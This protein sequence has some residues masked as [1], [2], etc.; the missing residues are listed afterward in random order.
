MNY[1]PNLNELQLIRLNFYLMFIKLI[2]LLL[3][4]FFDKSFQELLNPL[5]LLIV[6]LNFYLIN[7][8]KK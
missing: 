4:I 6:L 7:F 3:H 8:L 2:F 1:F 5:N